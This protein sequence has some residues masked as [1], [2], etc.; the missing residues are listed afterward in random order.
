MKKSAIILKGFSLE[1][2]IKDKFTAEWKYLIEGDTILNGI[3][4]QRSDLCR[5]PHF[6][7]FSGTEF[8]T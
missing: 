1:S 4:I 3:A 7:D 5:W 8:F 2:R 6:A